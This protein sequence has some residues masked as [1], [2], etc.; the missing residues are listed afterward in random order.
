MICNQDWVVMVRVRY[1][2]RD[3]SGLVPLSGSLRPGSQCIILKWPMLESTF[4]RFWFA[5]VGAFKKFQKLLILQWGSKFCLL[6]FSPFF[7]CWH[8]FLDI[9]LL[10]KSVY[11]GTQSSDFF[12]NFFRWVF[13]QQVLKNLVILDFKKK[14]KNFYILFF[15]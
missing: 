2:Q 12:L 4:A 7:G 14:K 6:F 5:S 11:P 1:I 9:W 13:W 15:F 8:C 3:L 10:L